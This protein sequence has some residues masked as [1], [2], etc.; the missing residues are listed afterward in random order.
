MQWR[1]SGQILPPLHAQFDALINLDLAD[2]HIRRHDRPGIVG[3]L[4]QSRNDEA[5]VV[6][7]AVRAGLKAIQTLTVGIEQPSVLSPPATLLGKRTKLKQLPSLVLVKLEQVKELDQGV[8]G[9]KL[10]FVLNR[11]PVVAGEVHR[12][13]DELDVHSQLFP[14]SPQPE[15]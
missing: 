1:V 9:E 3:G 15:G 11:R 12:P 4:K 7:D 5:L 13:G 8:F 2:G 6:A 10:A 14:A